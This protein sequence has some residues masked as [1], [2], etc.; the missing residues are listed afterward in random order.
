[1]ESPPV[2]NIQFAIPPEIKD[3]QLV[4]SPEIYCNEVFSAVQAALAGI[5]EMRKRGL[6]FS[7][8]KIFEINKTFAVKQ[9]IHLIEMNLN[10]QN[11]APL[12]AVP[13]EGLN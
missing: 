6:S 13:D 12:Y 8:E 3:V 10:V 11:K 1:M 4:M 7:E 9:L 5:D 2:S